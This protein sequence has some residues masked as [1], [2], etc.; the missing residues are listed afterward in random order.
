M[1]YEDFR[2]WHERYLASPE[3]AQVRVEVWR[4]DAS[5]CRRC[6]QPVGPGTE[7][8][9]ADCHH[10]RG[11]RHV[12]MD[13]NDEADFDLEVEGCLLVCRPCHRA[14]HGLPPEELD[15]EQ[16]RLLRDIVGD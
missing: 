3:F 15:E 14:V 7:L 13:D 6:H 12:L 2:R 1:S 5:T 11:Y 4:R 16:R 8:P 10:D 9:L